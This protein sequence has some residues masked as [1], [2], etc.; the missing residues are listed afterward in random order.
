MSFKKAVTGV[1]VSPTG[2]FMCTSHHGRVGLS[3]WADQRSVACK[4]IILLRA[5]GVCRGYELLFC[6]LVS[7]SVLPRP[8]PQRSPNRCCEARGGKCFRAEKKQPNYA[9]GSRL[10][11][12]RRLR[13][14]RLETAELFFGSVPNFVRPS[15]VVLLSEAPSEHRLVEGCCHQSSFPDAPGY[16]ETPRYASW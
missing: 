7:T 9:G 2:E 1:T 3:V 10:K 12:R 14:M 11:S 15:C 16:R 4:P 6:R 5:F 13:T 8:W